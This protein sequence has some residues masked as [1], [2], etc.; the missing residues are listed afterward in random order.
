MNE[1]VPTDLLEAFV[2]GHVP[3]Q[4]ACHIAEHLDS[5]P[6]C[7]NRV[8]ALEPLS[9]VFASAKDPVLPEDL[10]AAILIE[11]ESPAARPVVEL[12]L[13]LGLLLAASALALVQTSL[14]DSV[15]TLTVLADSLGHIGRV[16]ASH[17]A[18]YQGVLGVLTVAAAAGC[19]ATQ[20]YALA[21]PDLALQTRRL[22]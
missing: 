18:A 11:A 5:C 21:Q 8:T 15:T 13:G 22:S 19:W 16:S 14:L 3:E 17:M 12:A 10:V 7:L 9:P 6:G 20:R 1:H 4:L 2:E